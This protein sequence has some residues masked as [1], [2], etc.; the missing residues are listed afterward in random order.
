MQAINQTPTDPRDVHPTTGHFL[1]NCQGCGIPVWTD[2]A[3][4][5]YCPGC[6]QK[7]REFEKHHRRSWD[8][9]YL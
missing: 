9:K 4:G 1:L 7:H 5:A 2:P 3:K 6:L 8:R